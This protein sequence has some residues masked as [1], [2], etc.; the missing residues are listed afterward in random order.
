MDETFSYLLQSA[1]LISTNKAT[2]EDYEFITELTLSVEDELILKYYSTITI[3]KIGLDYNL[4][5][6]LCRFLLRYYEEK[7]EYEKCKM[8]IDKMNNSEKLIDS[9]SHSTI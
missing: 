5:I 2:E 1:R 8:I 4:F 9:I 6:K 7:E 3:P